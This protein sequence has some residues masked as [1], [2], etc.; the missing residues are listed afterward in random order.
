[1]ANR[2]FLCCSDVKSIYPSFVDAD[3]DAGEQTIASDVDTIPAL[4][5]AMFRPPDMKQK[6]FNVDGDRVKGIAPLTTRKKA[7]QQLKEALPLFNEAFREEGPLNEHFRLMSQALREASGK[8]ITVES[9]EVSEIFQSEDEFYRQFRQ[10]LRAIDQG[11]ASQLRKLLTDLSQ[12]RL[13]R[14]L[15]IG[16]RHTFPS[17]RM[18]LDQ[19]EYS[20]S[21][22]WN[23]TRLMGAGR[24][25]S[26]GLGRDV[27]WE[28]KDADYGFEFIPR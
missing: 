25:G 4:W 23:F 7:F 10:T 5:F 15:L 19:L 3:Y 18:Y 20:R 12:L 16:K 13:G 6:T 27:P 11:D 9:E 21:E 17:A 24:L 2:S 28:S 26:M 14:R 22:Q 1:M 8:F